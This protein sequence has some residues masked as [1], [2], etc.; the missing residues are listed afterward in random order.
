MGSIANR[1][2]QWRVCW[3]KPRGMENASGDGE[4]VAPASRQS[5]WRVC[6]LSRKSLVWLVG[7][8]C[9]GSFR[10]RLVVQLRCSG[11]GAV[12]QV[13]RNR[14]HDG[15]FGLFQKKFLAYKAMQV[16]LWSASFLHSLFTALLLL[17]LL[18]ASSA[19]LFC[20]YGFGLLVS[21][22][23]TEFF[24][25]WCDILILIDKFFIYCRWSFCS[26]LAY[27]FW[28]LVLVHIWGKLI[29]FYV[30]WYILLCHMHIC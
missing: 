3:T 28:L 11:A 5:F 27:T 19:P 14:H 4:F 15:W 1:H 20:C 21:M 10:R 9:K 29:Y 25:F 23:L 26:S 24:F 6:A 17:P 7:W 8:L 30:V 2:C 18:F 13:Q 22:L 12:L 16:L